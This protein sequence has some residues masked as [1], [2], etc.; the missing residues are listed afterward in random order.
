M[1]WNTSSISKI[2]S[3][4]AL[5]SAAT[6]FDCTLVYESAMRAIRMFMSTSGTKNENKMNMK[7]YKYP[8]SSKAPN[9]PN[10]ST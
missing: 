1:N 6:A 7:N 4:K 5:A 9:S 10:D 2:I 8:N 3:A